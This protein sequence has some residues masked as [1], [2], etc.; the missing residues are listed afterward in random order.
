MKAISAGVRNEEVGFTDEAGFTLLEVITAIFIFFCGIVGVLSLFTTAL[1]L[2][3]T[4]QDRTV[5]TMAVERIIADVGAMIDAGTLRSAETGRLKPL[6]G[7]PLPGHPDYTYA[8][9]FVEDE[10]GE[11]TESMVLARI[12]ISWRRRGK[13]MGESF[14]YVFRPGGGL[15]KEVPR[16][17]AE[18]G[19]ARRQ[20]L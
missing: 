1:V 16:L 14:D 6:S 17:R 3:K 15:G 9:D 8:V 7:I 10:E 19:S 20:G 11:A 4:S 13:E 2:H 5:S 18:S 12:R